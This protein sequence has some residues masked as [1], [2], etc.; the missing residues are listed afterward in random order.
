[1]QN[2]GMSFKENYGPYL[3][4]GTR[5]NSA[6]RPA[7][8]SGSPLGR[9]PRPLHFPLAP[10][11]FLSLL[12]CCCVRVGSDG[13]CLADEKKADVSLKG[14]V[15]VTEG[16]ETALMDAL[17]SVGPVSI[18]IDASHPGFSFYTGGVY[19]RQQTCT[20]LLAPAQARLS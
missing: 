3:M 15:N 18:S 19:V 9:L 8:P 16:D 13:Y 12:L 10:P 5:A 6:N 14:F 11:Q 7:K 20:P 17:A 4:Q 1:M 2:G